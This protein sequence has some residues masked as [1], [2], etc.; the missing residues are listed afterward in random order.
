MVDD[1][2]Q[3][4]GDDRVP[5]RDRRSSIARTNQI[6]LEKNEGPDLETSEQRE[7]H[8]VI[9]FEKC[10]TL[11]DWLDIWKCE[12]LQLFFRIWRENGNPHIMWI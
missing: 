7:E 10:E 5:S 12:K 6:P 1:E 9:E 3:R 8:R 4:G 11:Y 2:E